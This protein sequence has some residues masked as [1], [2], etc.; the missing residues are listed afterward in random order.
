MRH[1]AHSSS[2][3]TTTTTTTAHR[4]KRVFQPSITSFF[5]PA[6]DDYA[7]ADEYFDIDAEER[8]PYP[9]TRPSQHRRQRGQHRETAFPTVP[10]HIQ[11]DL[12]SVGMRVRKSVPEGY[13]THK[14]NAGLSLP[15]IQ[16]TLS[17]SQKTTSSTQQNP[18]VYSVKP[19]RD[20]VPDALQHQRELLP[21]C[22]LHKIG[23][24]AEQP[25]TNMHLY[26]GGG[27]GSGRD[28]RPVNL[29]PLPAEAFAQPF[30]SQSSSSTAT[31]SSSD[32]L[33]GGGPNPANTQKR[34]WRDD[35]E[36]ATANAHPASPF[37]FA[38][39]NIKFVAEDE[40]PV[41]PL[42]ATPAQGIPATGSA[43]RPFAQPKTRRRV[44][45][46]DGAV[47]K[48]ADV[49]MEVENAGEARRESRGAN[50]FEEAPFLQPWAGNG[51]EVEMGG[52]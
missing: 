11:A 51:E 12:L 16:T 20:P 26:G 47:F 30:S 36:V 43:L 14:S 2:P 18:D 8:G 19:P 22:G 31:S 33:P 25:V 4:D 42:S 23:G 1:A 41:S 21:F 49:E 6:T 24:Y 44:V 39:P 7:G 29:F 17:N 5:S 3:G 9:I 27:G 13:K 46:V 32:S 38:L 15:S 48:E 10:G 37:A 28:D 34:S 50:D 40:V 35:D 45:D 52:V